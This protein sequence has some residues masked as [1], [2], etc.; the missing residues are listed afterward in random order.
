MKTNNL[1]RILLIVALLSVLFLEFNLTIA[2]ISVRHKPEKLNIS[3]EDLIRSARLLHGL[4]REKVFVVEFFDYEC[5]PCRSGHSV[6]EKAI[7]EN[8]ITF[9]IYVSNLPLPIHQNARDLANI[10]SALSGKEFEKFHKQ[11]LRVTGSE[12]VKLVE[13]YTKR[14]TQVDP[15]WRKNAESLVSSSES[16][17]QLMGVDSTPTFIVV[18]KSKHQFVNCNVNQLTDCVTFMKSL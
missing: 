13:Q 17:A 10:G 11:A 12:T 15:E 3:P 8:E 16:H 5:P 7:A 18:N 9:P 4:E 14:L 6:I 2:N 1:D